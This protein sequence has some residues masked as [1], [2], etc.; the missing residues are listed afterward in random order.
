MSDAGETDV[1][2]DVTGETDVLS[3]AL[4]S[5][6][7]VLTDLAGKRDAPDGN[8]DAPNDVPSKTAVQTDVAGIMTGRLRSSPLLLWGA[9]TGMTCCSKKI[10][11]SRVHGSGNNE[12][13]KK[14][15]STHLE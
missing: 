15:I 3:D 6:T 4:T 14:L 1:L 5:N 10:L 11:V 2:S 7:D 12:L 13:L 9:P 8:T